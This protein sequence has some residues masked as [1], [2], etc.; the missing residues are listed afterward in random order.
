MSGPNSISGRILAARSHVELWRTKVKDAE[1][2]LKA[3]YESM[4]RGEAPD[5]P[6]QQFVVLLDHCARFK[7]QLEDAE[8][9]LRTL[10]ALQN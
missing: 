4:G 8:T 1:Q 2:Q 10:E 7:V 5:D 3:L 9:A 6:D